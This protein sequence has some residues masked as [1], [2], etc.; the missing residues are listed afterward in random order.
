MPIDVPGMDG[1]EVLRRVVDAD[2]RQ[3]VLVL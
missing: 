1:Y 2:S 3:R